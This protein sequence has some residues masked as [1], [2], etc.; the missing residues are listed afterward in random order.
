MNHAKPIEILEATVNAGVAKAESSFKKLFLLG[1]L[2]GAYIAF[3]GLSSTL[4]SYGLLANSTT[5][6]LGK[7]LAGT[8]FAGG[9]IM[10]VLAGAEL[11]TGNSLITLAVLEKKATVAKMARNL[12]IVYISNFVGALIIVGIANYIDLFAVGDGLMG[13]ISVKTAVGKVNMSFGKA[14][15]SG[16]LCNWLVCLAVWCATG[17][18]TT[19]DKVGAIFFP[20]WIFVICGFEHCIANMY[21]IP[22][23]IFAA[24]NE[25]FVALSGVSSDALASLNWAGMFINNML[26][27]TIGNILGGSIFVAAAYWLAYKK[28]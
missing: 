2:A 9:L 26:P 17:G 12:V 11:F 25:T 13:A 8:I 5:F 14:L 3:A 16:V 6:G 7:A 21:F 10:V 24:S 4:A 22:A 28:S 1:I 27:V 23:G 20:I 15:L 19:I 18:K